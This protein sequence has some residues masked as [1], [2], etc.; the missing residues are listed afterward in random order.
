MRFETSIAMIAKAVDLMR[1]TT[2]NDKKSATRSRLTA[3]MQH[4]VS[5]G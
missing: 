3:L 2:V 4:P 1:I 5:K